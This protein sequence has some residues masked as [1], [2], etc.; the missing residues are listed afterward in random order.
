MYGYIII[1]RVTGMTLYAIKKEI[2]KMKKS[3]NK[4][5]KKSMKCLMVILSV[6]IISGLTGCGKYQSNYSAVMHVHTNDSESGSMS[7]SE[8]EGTESFKL[9]CTDSDQ[10]LKYSGKLSKGNATVYYDNG[11][12]KTELF[13]VSSGEEIDSTL[14]GLEKGDLYIIVE[15]DEKCEEGNF[16]FEL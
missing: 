5:M 9:K 14:E 2:L 11:G 13:K 7:F 10:K 8:F 4:S 12:N 16:S 15:T 3:M 1:Y 6:L